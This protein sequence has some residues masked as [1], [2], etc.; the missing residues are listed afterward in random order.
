MYITGHW[1][2]QHCP[3]TTMCQ[4]HPSVP[5]WVCLC[6]FCPFLPTFY[7]FC[8]TLLYPSPRLSSFPLV[9]VKNESCL[10]TVVRGGLCRVGKERSSSSSGRQDGAGSWTERRP[11]T[12]LQVSVTLCHAAEGLRR[13]CTSCLLVW[14]VVS[15]FNGDPRLA[16]FLSQGFVGNNQCD[17]HNMQVLYMC[18][19]NATPFH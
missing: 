5:L 9:P 18:T 10:H 15:D 16:Q 2:Q 8:S 17:H 7:P 6:P 19:G 4:S 14:L 12:L 11:C 13:G 3:Y 1:S